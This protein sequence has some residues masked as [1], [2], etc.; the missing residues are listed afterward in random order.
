MV[1]TNELRD[2]ICQDFIDILKANY[3]E[4]WKE[5]LTAK[6]T[7]SPIQQ[8]AEQRGVSISDVRKV[9]RQVL[10]GG[11]LLQWY[12][13]LLEPLPPPSDWLLSQ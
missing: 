12:T 10:L 1:L 4:H 11:R 5:K 3:G 8:I 13:S 2:L 9:R 7:P 6:L